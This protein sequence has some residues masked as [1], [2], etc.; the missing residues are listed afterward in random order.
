MLTC[1]WNDAAESERVSCITREARARRQ[2]VH[3]LTFSILTASTGARVLALISDASSVGRTIRVENALGTT[4]LVRIPDVLR[5]A[6]ARTSTVLFPADSVG[7]ARRRLARGRFFLN[8]LGCK[9]DKRI[10]DVKNH[11]ST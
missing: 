7:T 2:V 4:S 10:S 8:G 9:G 11:D 6:R 1:W 3:D 5:K